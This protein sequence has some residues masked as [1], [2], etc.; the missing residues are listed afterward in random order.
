MQMYCSLHKKH[1]SGKCKKFVTVGV[2][3]PSM[4]NTWQFRLILSEENTIV[5]IFLIKSS[6]NKLENSKVIF[7]S[8]F[9][10]YN[11]NK[12]NM[13]FFLSMQYYDYHSIGF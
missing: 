3:M 13:I 8:S 6:G 1:S 4:T 2:C 9:S 7:H 11:Y 10:L 12:V 5:S